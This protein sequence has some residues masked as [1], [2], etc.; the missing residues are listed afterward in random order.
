MPKSI[1]VEKGFEELEK[2]AQTLESGDLTLD[3]MMDLY[4]RGMELTGIIKNKIEKAVVV[5][6]EVYKNNNNF[7]E[8]RIE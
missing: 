5:I 1:S 3:E 4:K 8:E 7:F 2:I 6:E